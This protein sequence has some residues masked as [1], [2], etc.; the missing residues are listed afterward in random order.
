MTTPDRRRPKVACLVGSPL[1][2][3]V[4]RRAVSEAAEVCGMQVVQAAL[5]VVRGSAR[6]SHAQSFAYPWQSATAVRGPW[7]GQPQEVTRPEGAPHHA[8]TP[9]APIALGGTMCGELCI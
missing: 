7:K 1:E 9:A 5:R 2:Q 3:G 6:I 4:R 8:R